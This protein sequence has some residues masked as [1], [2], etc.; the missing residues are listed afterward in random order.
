MDTTLAGASHWEQQLFSHLVEH[1]RDEQVIMTRYREAC[2]STDSEAFQYLVGLIL[3]EEDRHHRFTMEIANAL[4]SDVE[5]AEVTPRVPVFKAWKPV[6]RAILDAT[7]EF[8]QLEREDARH[9][10]QLAKDLRDTRDVTLWHLLVTLMQV[11]TD[12]HIQILEFLRDHL[13][14]APG[15]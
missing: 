13:R 11:D 7:R 14:A 3:E 12:K 2:L 5:F 10:K 8:L 15:G 1:E 9:L 4:R 6:D